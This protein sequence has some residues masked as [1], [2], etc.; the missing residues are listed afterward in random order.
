MNGEDVLIELESASESRLARS[1][2]E[3]SFGSAADPGESIAGGA[4]LRT[5]NSSL[6]AFARCHLAWLRALTESW[7]IHL[8][9]DPDPQRSSEQVAAC[10]LDS[11]AAVDGSSPFWEDMAFQIEDLGVPTAATHEW[12]VG[13]EGLPDC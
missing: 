3:L 13:R 11:V 4:V 2:V 5:V 9:E 10:F 12:L 7:E 1:V 8:T 6:A